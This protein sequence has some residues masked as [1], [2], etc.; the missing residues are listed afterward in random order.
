LATYVLLI[1][2]PK[3]QQISVGAKGN[4]PLLGGAYLYVGSARKSWEKRVAR[5]CRK[6]K[7]K[8]WHIDYILDSEGSAVQEVWVSQENWECT[9]CKTLADLPETEVPAPGIGSS[10][11]RCPAHFLMAKTG[12]S[13]VRENLEKRGFQEWQQA[14]SKANLSL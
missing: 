2:L 6:D 9:T 12:F 1:M 10:D 11:C 4:I 14:Q 7:K 5:H 8:R 13:A 3:D